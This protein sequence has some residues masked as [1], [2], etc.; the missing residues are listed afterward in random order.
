MRAMPGLADEHVVRFLRQHE[1]RRARERIERALR[2]RQQLGLAVA[3]G[4]HREHEE[5]EPVLD[6][7]VEGVEDARLVAVAALPREQLLGFVAAVAAEIRMQQVDH[8]P[9]MAA[10]LD[11]HLEQVAEVVDARA[12]LPQPPLLLD[13]RRLGVPLRHDQAPQLVPELARHFLPDR[14]PQEIAKS[15]PAIVDRIGEENAPAVLGQ[16]HVLEVRPSG[17]IDADRR[18]HVDLVI[19]LEPLRAHVLPPLDVLRAASARARAAAACCW[20]GRRC[21]ESFRRRS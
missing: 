10:L 20:R 14:L 5:V 21:S 12:P 2:Q 19:V 13:A 3:V 9:E 6:R 4:E 18:A 17:W 8:R 11:V 1:A 7:L 16:L 15:D